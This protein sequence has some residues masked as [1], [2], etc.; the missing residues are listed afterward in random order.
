MEKI[1]PPLANFLIA[2]TEKAGTTSVFVYL[3]QHPAVCASLIKETDFFRSGYTGDRVR[4]QELYS[5]YFCKY[6]ESQQVIM[7]A[8]PGYLGES[9]TVVSRIKSLL[10]D[11]KLLFILREPIDRLYSS[12]S[13]HVS[14]LDIPEEL[15]FAEFVQKCLAYDCG[16]VS[17][18]ELG[19]S[20]WH[21]KSLSFG[22]YAN[23]L[24]QYFMVFPRQNIK[25]MFYEKLS[26]DVL[27][28]MTEL[29]V[30]LKIDQKYWS[31]FN[32]RKSNVTFSGRNKALH[33]LA[34][35]LNNL[36]EPLLRQRPW[37][38]HPLV[39]FYKSLNQAASQREP[40]PAA[41]RQQLSDYYGGSNRRLSSLIDAELPESWS[42]DSDRSC[43]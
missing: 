22:R 1:T 19:L 39:N 9:E 33:K 35:G 15:S 27:E 32:F 23:Y 3:S 17:P 7:E 41:V 34:I 26:D 20:E 8:S 13:F 6:R 28:F 4:D 43:E 38:K 29:S 18:K 14:R 10:P 5:G 42:R 40:I 37:L 31:D 16:D 2:G 21:L 36:S 24:H 25:V 11:A 30:F 12:Y